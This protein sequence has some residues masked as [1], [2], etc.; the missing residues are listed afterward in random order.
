MSCAATESIDL[1]LVPRRRLS[2]STEVNRSSTRATGSLNLPS[3]RRANLSTRPASGCA[4][5]SRTGR[6]TTSRAG[7]HSATSFS[8][9]A[10]PAMA[11]SGCAVASSGSPTATPMRFK[12]KSKARTVRAARS[13]M[14]RFVLQPRVVDAKQLHRLGKALFGRYVEEDGIARFDREPRVLRKLLLE[15]AGRPARVAEGH[16]H[17]FGALAAADRFKNVLGGGEAD[18]LAHAQRRLPVTRGLVQH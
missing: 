5:C 13:G 7:R 10:K 2:A 18:H 17:A 16:E 14:S 4:P 3:S 15:L 8:I 12:P 11:G 1:C 6:P 9:S